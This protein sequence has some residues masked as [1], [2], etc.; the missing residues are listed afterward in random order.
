[1]LIALTLIIQLI[2]IHKN[3]IAHRDIKDEN[4]LFLIKD[5]NLYISYADFGTAEHTLNS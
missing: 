2:K 5:D 3:H 4:I 1:M